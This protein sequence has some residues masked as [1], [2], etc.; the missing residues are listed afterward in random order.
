MG[1]RRLSA[2]ERLI[3]YG[4]S[5]FTA[6]VCFTAA[7]D[8]IENGNRRLLGTSS[9]YIFFVYGLSIFIIEKLYLRLKG[10]C[11]LFPRG[12]AYITICYLFEFAFGYFLNIWNACP[13]D[14]ASYFDYHIMGLITMEYIPLWFCS[15][16]FC[17][18]YIIHFALN[19]GW[20]DND[21][22]E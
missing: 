22:E 5:G 11:R 20:I 21:K 12:L 4:C 3:I 2:I 9:I 19:I 13:W 7:W 10:K 16:L 8:A 6:E 1:I 14:Y 17:E 18:Q 15:S